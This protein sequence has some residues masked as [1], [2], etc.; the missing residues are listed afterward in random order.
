V[1][2]APFDY[3]APRTLAAALAALAE[4]GDEAK[5]IAGGQSLLPMLNLRVARP[6]VLVDV[7]RVAGLAGITVRDG[8]LRI[9]ARTRQADLLASR[10]AQERWPLIAEA[11]GHLAH[12][13][14]RNQGTV[15]GSLAHADPSAELP[16]VMTALHATMHV[17]SVRGER[18]IVAEDFFLT[19]FTTIL[20][21]DELLVEIVVPALPARTGTGFVEFARR[22]GDFALGG[23]ACTVTLDDAGR[24]D[25]A[26]AV[27]LAA[28]AVP[29]SATVAIEHLVGAFPTTDRIAKASR[30]Q[31]AALSPTGDMHGSTSWRRVLLERQL[32]DGLSLAVERT[33]R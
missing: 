25:A 12:P 19:H 15:G 2:P 18:Q 22:H 3:V 11:M 17:Q 7:G 8:I 6:A 28:G 20:E 23:A 32:R 31:V 24:V 13:Q 5:V 14:I 27:L 21:P 30:L 10:T 16:V 33:P 26:S 29:V 4:H 1:K 9:G